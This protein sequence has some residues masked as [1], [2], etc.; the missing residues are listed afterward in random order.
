V[1]IAYKHADEL[2]QGAIELA[3]RKVPLAEM[4]RFVDMEAHKIESEERA[5][6]VGG[7]ISEPYWENVERIMYLLAVKKFLEQC[8][9]NP[10][11]V[12]DWLRSRDG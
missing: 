6:I 2:M 9:D 11:K 1:D 8:R 10:G 12:A 5:R 3:E 7:I 4:A